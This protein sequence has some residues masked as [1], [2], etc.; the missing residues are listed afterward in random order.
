M[1]RRAFDP[2]YIGIT[3]DGAE[4]IVKHTQLQLVGIDYLSIGALDGVADTHRTLFRKARRA[5]IRVV[6]AV[7]SCMHACINAIAAPA[8]RS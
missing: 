2:S 3:P 7:D 4:F 5:R 1:Y 8:T 6:R